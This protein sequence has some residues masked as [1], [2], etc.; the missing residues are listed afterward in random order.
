MLDPNVFLLI[1]EQNQAKTETGKNIQLL[2]AAYIDGYIT[3]QGELDKFIAQL[4]KSKD[5]N[6]S[7]IY[8]TL[9]LFRKQQNKRYNEMCEYINSEDF[10]SIKED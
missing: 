4:Y 8:N 3:A 1:K 7:L 5:V 6:A 10:D 9:Q 2:E